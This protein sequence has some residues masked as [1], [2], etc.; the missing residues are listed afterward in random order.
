MKTIRKLLVANRGEIAVRIIR[1]CRELGIRSV[2]VYS[3]VDRTALHVQLA[4]EAYRLGGN[5][6]SESY[7]NQDMII[8]GAHHTSSD[9]IHPGYGFLSENPQFAE[10]VESEGLIFIGP[11]GAAI[12]ALGDKTAAR[13]L[14]RGLGIPTVQGSVE[15][16]ESD[17]EA[18]ACATSVGY[19]ILIKAAAGGGGKGM[20]I[21]R[22]ESDLVS[23]LQMARSEARTAFHDDR[24]YI[25]KY[26]DSPRHI[27]IQILA[28]D[29]GNIVYLGERDCSIQRRHQKV[30][31]ESP[32]LALDE[33]TRKQLG[34]SAVRLARAARYRNAGTLEFL[35]DQTQSFYFLEMNTRLQVEHPVTE[36]LTGLDLVREQIRIAEGHPL[37]FRQEDIQRSGHAIEC[38]ICAED[39]RNNFFPSSGKLK[40][41]KTP[42]GRTR[43]DNGYR[44]GDT[45]SLHYDSLLAKVIAHAPTREEAIGAMNRA[46][47][48]FRVQGVETTIPFCQYVLAHPAFL[49]GSFDTTF[50]ERHYTPHLL[51]HGKKDRS[52]ST[53]VP[54]PEG[55]KPDAPTDIAIVAALSA[56]LLQDHWRQKT[57]PV[58]GASDTEISRWKLL[59]REGMRE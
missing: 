30:I 37:P 4:D 33:R 13:Q 24:V 25:E 46:L 42:E 53:D 47:W 3:D 19:P 20:R 7:L 58:T 17:E 6:P 27:E 8:E 36:F 45:V 11:G 12:R 1:T 34:E 50:V 9:A 5:A 26:I 10:R 32:S 59:R 48:E 35:L 52:N 39:P 57:T 54:N 43:V 29:R 16:L 51:L 41:Y 23:S 56:V 55:L 28:D 44:E 21:V 18:F 31:E 38:R 49:S 15:A 40:R 22:E 14:A 2:A